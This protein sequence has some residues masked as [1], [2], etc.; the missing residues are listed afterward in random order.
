MNA[1][2]LTGAEP[3]VA[4]APELLTAEQ[5]ASRRRTTLTAKQAAILDWIREYVARNAMSP[6]L[7]EIG[8]AFGIR[9]TNGVN[10]HLL[11]LE[12]KGAIRRRNLLSRSIVIVDGPGPQPSVDTALAACERENK[13]LRTLLGRVADAASRAPVLTAEMVVVL[14]D[15]RAVLRSGG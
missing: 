6:T 2:T 8:A 12:K 9:S 1:P 14:G 3:A 7:R 4:D 11:A 5:I 15:V 10:D 13:A